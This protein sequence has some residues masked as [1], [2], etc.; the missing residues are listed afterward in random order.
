[1]KC[2][3]KGL[4][5]IK[6]FEACKLEAYRCP[7]GIWTVG[8]GSTEGV[9]DGMRITMGEALRRLQDHLLP[10]ELQIEHLVKAPLSQSAFDALCCLTYNIGIGAFEHSTLL[11]RLNA[12]DHAGA[13]DQFLVWDRV[14][15]APCP[16]LAR[17]RQAER[18]LF[19]S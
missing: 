6:Q 13:A 14:R 12:G 1:M 17:R 5:L 4:S 8:F 7:A 11:Q 18:A 3:E 19:L 15:G 16:G 10:L 2:G 9:Y